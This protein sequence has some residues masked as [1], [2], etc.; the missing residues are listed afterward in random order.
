V[1]P[2]DDDLEALADAY[3]NLIVAE[4]NKRIPFPP[5]YR[6]VERNSGVA[7]RQLDVW[8]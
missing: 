5:D 6:P 7:R 4:D 2:A 1:D 8:A 3:M